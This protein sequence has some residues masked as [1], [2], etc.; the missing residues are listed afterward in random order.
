MRVYNMFYIVSILFT[1]YF[2]TLYVCTEN[3][4]HKNKFKSKFIKVQEKYSALSQQ[5]KM[6]I[7]GTVSSLFLLLICGIAG[8]IYYLK[9]KKS[10]KNDIADTDNSGNVE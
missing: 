2:M 10:K 6:L 5:H 7:I 4:D 1:L 9:K 8:G 3:I